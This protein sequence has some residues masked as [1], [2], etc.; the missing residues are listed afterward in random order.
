MKGSGEG[1]LM[2][3]WKERSE[4]GKLKHLIKS[5]SPTVLSDVAE[6][7]IIKVKE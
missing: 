2:C 1:R 4:R 6:K 7:R 5:N 3:V